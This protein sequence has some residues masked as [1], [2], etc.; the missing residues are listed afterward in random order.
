[1]GSDYGGDVQ[2]PLVCRMFVAGFQSIRGPTLTG[3]GNV[4]ACLLKLSFL[5]SL[6]C[7][8]VSDGHF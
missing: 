4:T 5:N 3:T 8:S 1:V 6:T 2:Q 7:R